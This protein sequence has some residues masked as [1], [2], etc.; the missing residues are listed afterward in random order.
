M[1]DKDKN[2]RQPH[3]F[4]PI[5]NG[6]DECGCGFTFDANIHTK[7]AISNDI[8][9]PELPEWTE[10]QSIFASGASTPLSEF[11]RNY[12]P[13][14]STS[15]FKRDDKEWRVALGNLLATVRREEREAV[16][17]E[18]AESIINEAGKVGQLMDLASASARKE[19]REAIKSMLEDYF[20]HFFCTCH[21]ST[22]TGWHFA[23]CPT[24]IRD[25][26][27]G[28]LRGVEVSASEKGGLSDKNTLS[29]DEAAAAIDEEDD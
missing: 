10:C 4:D 8:Q 19:E 26:V 3:V 24:T 1:S 23:S 20:K 15:P 27:L 22:R 9:V 2:Y 18:S 16:L 21:G 13:V 29:T 7:E 25:E 14:S 11:I 12:E 5:H 28:R 6:A 17:N